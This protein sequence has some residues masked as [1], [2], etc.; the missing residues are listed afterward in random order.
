MTV[1]IRVERPD[2]NTRVF[3]VDGELDGH[4]GRAFKKQVAREAGFGC[5][6][7]FDLTNLSYLDGGG[8]NSLI[9]LHRKCM[10]RGKTAKIIAGNNENVRRMLAIAGT[11]RLIPVLQTLEDIV[12][13]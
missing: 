3:R 4:T 13:E 10:K 7:I 5:D 11:D 8:I 6:L 2:A 1:E 12:P 9:N